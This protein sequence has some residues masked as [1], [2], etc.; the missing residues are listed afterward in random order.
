MTKHLLVLLLTVVALV[1]PGSLRAEVKS[2]ELQHIAAEEILP[3]VR[4]LLGPEVRVSALHNRL[5]VRG[6]QAD[7]A[8]FEKIVRQL[9][10]ARQMLRV[11]LRQESRQVETATRFDAEGRLIGGDVVL[12]SGGIEVGAAR[13]LGTAREARDQFV[14]VLDGGQAR[15][16]VGEAAPF[17]REMAVLVDRHGGRGYAQSVDFQEVATGFVV[18]PLRQ[19][20]QVLLEVTPF[21]QEFAGGGS[22]AMGGARSVIF[23]EAAT[24]VRV[25]L[26][27]WYDLAGHLASASEVG[28]AFVSWRTGAEEARRQILV[29]VDVLP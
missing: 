6:A 16:L 24:R 23:Q 2:L 27:T 19:G 15:I 18:Q 3:V 1:C 5:I 13:R 7:L 10:V 26:G 12:G 28:A 11:T 17:T 25:P 8:D 4:E 29:R 14:Q 21:L 9:D 20:E 22:P